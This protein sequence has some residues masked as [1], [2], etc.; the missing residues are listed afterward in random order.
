MTDSNADK[1]APEYRRYLRAAAK[2]R[3]ASG[4][5]SD[6]LKFGASA[7][8]VT[9]DSLQIDYCQRRLIIPC[10][11]EGIKSDPVWYVLDERKIALPGLT[12]KSKILCQTLSILT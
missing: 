10:D 7:I 1:L 9:I 8:Q 4:G 6:A 12:S 11:Y 3:L 2:I 5:I